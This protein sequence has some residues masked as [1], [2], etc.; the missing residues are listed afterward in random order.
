MV[1]FRQVA[2]SPDGKRVAWVESG[3]PEGDPKDAPKPREFVEG[4]QL[5]VPDLVLSPTEDMIVGPAGSD[6]FFYQPWWRNL[7]ENA[8]TVQFVHRMVAYT[9]WIAVALH[10]VDALA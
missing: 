4:W 8:L 1:R 5:G 6:L 10:A 3:T 7:F 2:L 9:L